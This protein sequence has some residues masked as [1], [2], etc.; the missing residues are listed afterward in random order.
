MSSKRRLPLIPRNFGIDLLWICFLEN[1][2]NVEKSNFLK[3]I[4]MMKTVSSEDNELSK[5]VVNMLGCMTLREPMILVLEFM[6]Y[7]NLLDYI[8]VIQARVS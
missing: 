3:E 2:T 7:G 1:A 5:F 4:E 6:K 8:R